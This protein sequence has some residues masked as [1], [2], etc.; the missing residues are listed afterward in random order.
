[1]TTPAFLSLMAA[2]IALAALFVVIARSL[3][4]LRHCGFILLALSSVFMMC[5]LAAV[6]TS[7]VKHPSTKP[8][9]SP[10]Y[11]PSRHE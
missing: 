9:F 1:M 10:S 11:L 8:V 4:V 2:F 5:I 6:V 3:G 7:L